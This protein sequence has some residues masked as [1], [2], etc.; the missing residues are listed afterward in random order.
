M[1]KN[2]NKKLEMKYSCSSPPWWGFLWSL[3]GVNQ[4]K[5][6]TR[7]NLISIFLTLNSFS[8]VAENDRNGQ[9]ARFISAREKWEKHKFPRQILSD[10]ILDFMGERE[11]SFSSA[12]NQ[13]QRW[14]LIQFFLLHRRRF[15]LCNFTTWKYQMKR[16]FSEENPFQGVSPPDG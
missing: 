9:K 5:F 6:V 16:C 2:A 4:H 10:N 3:T 14:N 8:S 13:K 15:S 1:A 11:K 7:W 12:F